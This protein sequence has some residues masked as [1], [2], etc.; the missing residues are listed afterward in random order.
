MG[1][2]ASGKSLPYVAGGRIM[3]RKAFRSAEWLWGPHGE[4]GPDKNDR[5]D[6]I[7]HQRL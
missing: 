2:V 1:G 4:G 7:D 5:E 6:G 3:R